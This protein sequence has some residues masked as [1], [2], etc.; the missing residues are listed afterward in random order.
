MTRVKVEPDQ[1]A[2]VAV[3]V[4]QRYTARS[5]RGPRTVQIEAVER[6]R[7]PPIAS[8][9]ELIRPSCDRVILHAGN[10]CGCVATPERHAFAI[11]LTWR[12]GAWFLPAWYEVVAA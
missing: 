9:R 6:D 11:V 5:P 2:R 1:V 4:G 7:T 10:L 8:A 3:E 12:D